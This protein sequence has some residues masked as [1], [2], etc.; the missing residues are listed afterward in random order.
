MVKEFI[1]NARLDDVYA[2]EVYET[3]EYYF[4]TTTDALDWYLPNADYPEA[5]GCTISVEFN[6]KL[7]LEP[8]YANVMI[9]PVREDDDGGTEDYDYTYVYMEYEDIE[10]LIDVIYDSCYV[11][12]KD[13]FVKGE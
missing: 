13:A 4:T 1:K 7:S 8:R 11:D 5:I 12:L 3:I 2:S 10:W 9:S 6:N